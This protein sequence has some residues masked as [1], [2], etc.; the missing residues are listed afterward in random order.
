MPPSRMPNGSCGSAVIRWADPEAVDRAVRGFARSLLASHPEVRRVY[1]YGSWVTGIPTPSS[2]VDLCVVVSHDSRRPRDRIPDYLPERFPTGVD[3]T[4][5]TEEEL[6]ELRERSPAWYR[7][8]IKGREI[9]AEVRPD[10]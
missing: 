4:V 3:L 2:D 6:Q 7:A 5:L 10:A 8:I 9:G 1:W